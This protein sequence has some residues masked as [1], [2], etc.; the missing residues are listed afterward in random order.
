MGEWLC[1]PLKIRHAIK[2]RTY[3]LSDSGHDCRNSAQY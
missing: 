3:H 2:T 1:A